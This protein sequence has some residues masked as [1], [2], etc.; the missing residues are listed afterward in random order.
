MMETKKAGS[1][2]ALPFSSFDFSCPVF[3]LTDNAS[4]LFMGTSF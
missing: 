4:Q 1:S 3:E 2:L